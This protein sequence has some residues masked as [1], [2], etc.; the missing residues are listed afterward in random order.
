MVGTPTAAPNHH[1]R[2]S[3]R[4]SARRSIAG[5]EMGV[6]VA[7]SRTAA[8]PSMAR[9]CVALVMVL[10]LASVRIVCSLVVGPACRG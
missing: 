9:V 4:Y 3:A 5:D 8:G 1:L 6:T 7:V 2:I 10:C